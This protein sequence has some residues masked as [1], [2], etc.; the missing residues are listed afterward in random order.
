MYKLYAI[1]IFSFQWQE[2][3]EF[4]RDVLGLPV[5]FSDPERGWAQFD[6]SGCYIG[7]ERCDPADPE[8]AALVGRFVGASIQVD[9]V[10]A[11]YRNLLQ[12][13]VQFTGEPIEQSWGGVLAHFKDVDGNIVT[14]LGI[15][16]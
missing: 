5:H 13:G 7:L 9:D 10:H 14:L 2:S 3:F 8:S 6:L 1:R 4:Y 15:G 16:G 12:R 11:S